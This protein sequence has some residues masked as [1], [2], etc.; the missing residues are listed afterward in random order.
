MSTRRKSGGRFRGAKPWGPAAAAMLGLAVMAAA[1]SAAAQQ[2]AAVDSRTQAEAE[3]RV[4]TY[5]GEHLQPGRPLLVTQLYNQ[6][7]TEP[8]ER[9]A[10]D[11]L[12]RAF[13]RIPLFVA[14]Y[15]QKF[16]RPPTLQT[17]SGQFD[18]HAPGAADVLLRVMQSDPRVPPFLRRDPR[19]GEI[20]HVDT[21]M[22]RSD[23][24]FGEAIDH[25]IAGWVGKPAPAFKLPGLRGG[26]VDL[27]GFAGKSVLLY[28]W[29]TGCPPC[30][31]ETPQLVDL[32]HAFNH[33]LEIIG[34]NAD[35]V[36]GLSYANS[37]RERYLAEHKVD[38]PVG[39]W[40]KEADAAYGG[41][42][43]F[44]TLFLIDPRGLVRGQ[45]VGFVRV[46]ELRNAVGRITSGG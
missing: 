43:I 24:E 26:D 7:F 3:A 37:V 35:R 11:K 6:V 9:A 13:F 17:I 36:L 16:G 18:L 38:F 2:P 46:Q 21:A 40:T 23:P 4:I 22:V 10:L 29:F 27:S 5:I 30:L 20:T 31:Q 12:Y 42:S 39:H 8:A 19:T 44:P 41:I 1:R 14:Q 34:A 33:H 25:Q 45:W 32:G 28:V 15:Q